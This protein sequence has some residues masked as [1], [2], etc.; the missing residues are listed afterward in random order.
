M[1][2][3]VSR[4]SSFGFGFVFI[5]LLSSLS[6][7]NSANV[8]DDDDGIAENSSKSLQDVAG[9][10]IIHPF[11]LELC[12]GVL[13]SPGPH[14]ISAGLVIDV[15]DQDFF[16]A[17]DPF[18]FV[19][20]DPFFFVAH[21]PVLVVVLVDKAELISH[22]ASTHQ[23][24]AGAAAIAIATA[25][26]SPGIADPF[27][28]CACKPTQGT[29]G[30]PKTCSENCAAAWDTNTGKAVCTNWYK[31]CECEAPPSLC[32]PPKTCS[33][34]C[35]ADW[36]SN[37]CLAPASL[38]G[39]PK[40]CSANCAPAFDGNGVARC[41]GWY[42]GCQCAAP[43]S[44]CGEPKVCSANCAGAWDSN[45]VARCTRWYEGCQ[46]IAPASLC[47]TPK[48]CS[49][50][51]R[52]VRDSKTGKAYCTNWYK[53]CEC[54]LPDNAPPTPPPPPPPPPPQPSEWYCLGT[55]ER[56]T[57]TE[58]CLSSFMFGAKN[59]ENGAVSMTGTTD[60]NINAQDMC[61]LSIGGYVVVC[62]GNVVQPG[63]GYGVA[64]Y[65]GRSCRTR[66]NQESIYCHTD[67]K[68]GFVDII[69]NN[70]ICD[71]WT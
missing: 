69:F 9:Y 7:V 4:S 61:G 27:V 59:M 67:D 23:P 21:D 55:A 43:P 68:G 46:C 63:S 16:I 10:S 29:C 34:N 48:Q 28:G 18:F 47:G 50:N 57:C 51:C 38:C 26:L 54:K 53:G 3:L 5:T 8:S 30:P 32:G 39:Q 44:L 15:V 37:G 45:G 40:T 25:Y 41:K 65:K 22:A 62:Y 1:L 64:H 12:P 2:G 42:E 66:T 52:G 70:L 36:D 17:H 31:G 24:T 71:R 13:P 49:A 19:A 14:D 60:K 11:G 33:E 20:H 35:A 58:N 56:M 6:L